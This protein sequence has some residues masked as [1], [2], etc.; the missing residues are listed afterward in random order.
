MF[1]MGTIFLALYVIFSQVFWMTYTNLYFII[2]HYQVGATSKR[3]RR[4][5]VRQAARPQPCR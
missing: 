3:L 4:R 2:P 1:G 5:S